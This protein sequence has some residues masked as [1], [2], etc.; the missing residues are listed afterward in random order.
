[1]LFLK[2]L[3]PGDTQA[4]LGDGQ[5]TDLNNMTIT[6]LSYTLPEECKLLLYIMMLGDT[7][8]CIVNAETLRTFKELGLLDS[9][10]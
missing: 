7:P 1:M 8:P 2:L 9:L 4:I 6:S 3:V 10:S 5:L